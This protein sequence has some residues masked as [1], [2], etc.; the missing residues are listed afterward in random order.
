MAHCIGGPSYINFGWGPIPRR[1]LPLPLMW[2]LPKQISAKNCSRNNGHKYTTH[3]QS[4]RRKAPDSRQSK[5]ARAKTQGNPKEIRFCT[6]RSRGALAQIPKTI[7]GNNCQNPSG[8]P[9]EQGPRPK[10]IQRS[11]AQ[12]Q[13]NPKGHVPTSPRITKGQGISACS[14]G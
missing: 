9:R 11:R 1:I 2:H 7:K 12:T 14:N 6:K 8:N 5:G 10:A 3:K 13:G 4:V